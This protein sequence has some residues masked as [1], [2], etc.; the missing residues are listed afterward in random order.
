MLNNGNGT[1]GNG[2]NGHHQNGGLGGGSV[3]MTVAKDREHLRRSISGGWGIKPDDLERYRK[4]LDHAL[5]LALQA[6]NTREI[7]GC[8]NTMRSIV[9][10]IQ[11][12][13]HKLEPDIVDQ[14]IRVEY[15]NT[16]DRA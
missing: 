14:T 7:R 10:Q 11:K 5:A 16:W 13:E 6:G 3:D 15:V 9:D 4:A 2:S 8:I 12:D 1:N